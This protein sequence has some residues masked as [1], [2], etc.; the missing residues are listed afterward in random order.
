MQ[1]VTRKWSDRYKKLLV[2]LI[3]SYVFAQ[4]LEDIRISIYRQPHVVTIVNRKGKLLSI[5]EGEM[6]TVRRIEATR[7]PFQFRQCC[8]D[9]LEG[10][11]VHFTSGPLM[12]LEG[13]IEKFINK[14]K[15]YIHIPSLGGYFVSEVRRCHIF[16][17]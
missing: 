2:P 8:F 12:G 6:Q 3:P 14:L 15:V 17:L 13:I 10:Q 16:Y 1:M 5:S 7:L 4:G 11:R 9:F